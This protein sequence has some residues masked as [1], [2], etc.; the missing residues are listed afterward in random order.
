MKICETAYQIVERSCLSYNSAGSLTA[1]KQ[2]PVDWAQGEGSLLT[3]SGFRRG[4]FLRG[5]CLFLDL[6]V[7][8]IE[9]ILTS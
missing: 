7:V 2:K 5:K 8:R 9:I 6:V 4:R 1:L 3:P